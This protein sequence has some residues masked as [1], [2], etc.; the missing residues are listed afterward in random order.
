MSKPSQAVNSRSNQSPVLG[1]LGS[2]VRIVGALI[3][4]ILLGI[5]GLDLWYRMTSSSKPLSEH[6][7]NQ[8]AD[9]RY[10]FWINQQGGAVV[11]D[12]DGIVKDLKG[13]KISAKEVDNA[14]L[15]RGF[16]SAPSPEAW[17]S[18]SAGTLLKQPT[19]YGLTSLIITPDGKT[20][21]SAG[22]QVELWSLTTRS[23]IRTLSEQTEFVYAIAL[24]PDGKT[25]AT[26]DQKGTIALWNFNTGQLQRSLAHGDK[27]YQLRFSSDGKTLFSGGLDQTIKRWNLQT[28][29]MNRF[30]TRFSVQQMAFTPNE[31][32][33]AV[34]SDQS[35][36]VDIFF[37]STGTQVAMPIH[38]ENVDAI[39]FNSTGRILASASGSRKGIRLWDMEDRPYLYQPIK[40]LRGHQGQPSAI[41]F[42]PDDRTFFA[43]ADGFG[44]R[45][46]AVTVWD[47]CTGKLVHRFGDQV[48]GSSIAV[49]KDG[50]TLV[51]GGRKGDIQ[52]WQLP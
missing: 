35:N 12:S 47:A 34:G 5:W 14:C 50:K 51:T 10:M 8:W 43:T 24:S 4:L 15:G 18:M 31:Q 29:Q 42:S 46:Y 7:H 9:I 6:L 20:L 17:R 37:S 1:C 25:I 3:T 44:G 23:R 27:V 48:R 36:A 11:V 26:G 2:L 32:M 28:G 49:S 21:I 52:L 38:G 19:G 45:N 33:V 16:A 41:A 39:A 30:D 22:K 40:T 13:N